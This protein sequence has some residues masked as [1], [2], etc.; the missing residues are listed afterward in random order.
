[1]S[2][3]GGVPDL[4]YK[5][6]TQQGTHRKEMQL[7]RKQNWAQCFFSSSHLQV[8]RGVMSIIKYTISSMQKQRY[9][10]QLIA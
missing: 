2:I 10:V 7:V 4:I 6:G 3:I 5:D 8:S 9:A 1:M